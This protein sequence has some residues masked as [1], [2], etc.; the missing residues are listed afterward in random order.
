[1]RERSVPR[2]DSMLKNAMTVASA[3]YLSVGLVGY[4]AF[5]DRTAGNF[6]RNLNTQNVLGARGNVMR[7]LKLA[8]G[9]SVV[10]AVPTTIVP[11][12]HALLAAV[13]PLI[14][15]VPAVGGPVGLGAKPEVGQ[16]YHS[17]VTA[18][19]LLSTLL[20]VRTI[21]RLASSVAV[22]SSLLPASIL[23]LHIQTLKQARSL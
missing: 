6:L 16:L 12:R 19:I 11:L 8:F 15:G 7:I 20:M 14:G 1:M 17:V 9:L 23:L 10:G 18:V 22:N 3:L 13:A 2:V 4:A 5:R 21:A